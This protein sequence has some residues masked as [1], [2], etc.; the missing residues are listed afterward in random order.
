MKSNY[1]KISVNGRKVDE[2]RY[3]IE[4]HI[5]RKLKR[6][7]VVH[8]IDGNK[9]NN[10]LSNLQL[11]TL[12][13]HSRLHWELNGNVQNLEKGHVRVFSD[14]QAREIKRLIHTSGLSNR[15]IAKMM[16]VNRTT[17]DRIARGERYSDIEI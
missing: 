10:D 1:K 16:G 9:L 5:G 2:H 4:Q 3:I 15:K 12:E 11:M 6:N 8:H 17:I 13:E 7:E 14:D